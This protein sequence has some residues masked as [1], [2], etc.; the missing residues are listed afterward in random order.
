MG[1][2]GSLSL[3]ALVVIGYYQHSL[4]WV[5][6]FGIANNFIGAHYP[7]GK[8][9]MAKERGIYLRVLISSLPLQVI[10]AGLFYGLGYGLSLL[11]K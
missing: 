6:L 10:F 8:A 4:L 5:L 11:V 9:Q 7:P 1:Y 2:L 3:I